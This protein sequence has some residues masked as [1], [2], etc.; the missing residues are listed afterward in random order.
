MTFG[1]IIRSFSPPALDPGGI[2]FN[3]KN[4]MV[5]C[6]GDGRIHE[7]D[8]ETGLSIR[9]FPYISFRLDLGLMGNMLLQ[10]NGTT[11][12][13]VTDLLGNLIY[14][15]PAIESYVYGL[16][17]MGGGII[18]QTAYNLPADRNSYLS[19]RERGSSW[20]R[21]R[22]VDTGVRLAGLCFD[23]KDIYGMDYVTFRI[24]K[25]NIDGEV[26]ASTPFANRPLGVAFDGK[27]LWVT[28]DVTD[29][30]YCVSLN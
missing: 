6:G 5:A 9:S 15:L 7:V 13:Y 16:T 4:L 21:V 11:T 14:T 12:I 22:R 23:G 20:A 8:R 30:I 29:L 25:I 27:Y 10:T 24:T 3:G 1:D 26:I 18:I 19:F 28:N 17:W 2:V